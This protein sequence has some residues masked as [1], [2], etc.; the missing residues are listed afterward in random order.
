MDSY[1]SLVIAI[2]IGKDKIKIEDAIFV[3]LENQKLRKPT[4][5]SKRTID[6]VND[7]CGHSAHCDCN[8]KRRGTCKI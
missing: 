8:L 7:G 5:G 4:I 1:H 3:I 6:V 2:L